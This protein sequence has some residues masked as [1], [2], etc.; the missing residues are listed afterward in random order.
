MSLISHLEFEL[1]FTES[2]IQLARFILKD[3]EA[4]L[5][6]S[7]KELAQKTY[8]SPATIVRFC[9]K[10]GVDGYGDFKI[11][12]AS[13]LQYNNRYRID[14]NYPFGKEDS[15]KEIVKK[16]ATLHQEAINDTI[17]LIDYDKLDKICDKIYEANDIFVFG[18]GNSLT[19]GFEFQHKMSRLGINVNMRPFSGEESFMTSVMREKDIAILIS[20]S[21]ETIRIVNIAKILKS[22]NIEMI[23]ITSIG[24]NQISKFSNNIINVASREKIFNKMAPFASKTSISFILDVIFSIYFQKNYDYNCEFRLSHDKKYDHRHPLNSPID[25]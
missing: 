21:G 9:R 3:P 11:Q 14:V 25:K 15:H 7:I 16:L 8:S 6:L 13:E 2:E 19:A 24:E 5:K 18:E 22:R 20:Y 12:L 4:V 17:N 23:V 10:L 1:N